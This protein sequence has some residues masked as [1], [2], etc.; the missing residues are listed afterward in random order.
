MYDGFPIGHKLPGHGLRGSSVIQYKELYDGYAGNMAK[1]EM[2]HA[3]RLFV[4]L[5]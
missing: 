3:P 4:L 5:V 1:L 2:L